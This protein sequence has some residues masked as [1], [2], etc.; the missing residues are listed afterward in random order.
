MTDL[1]FFY[2]TLMSGFRRPGRVAA[3]PGATPVGRGWIRAAL[4]DLGIYPAAIPA[5]D[6][7]GL[8]RSAPDAGFATPSSRRWTRSKASARP[9]PTPASTPA[10]DAGDVR[11]RPRAPTPGSTSTTRRSAGRS[12]SSR[13]TT[14]NTSESD[15]TP[16]AQRSPSGGT[17]RQ[18]PRR[19]SLTR[20]NE[21]AR[22][23]LRARAPAAS[24][25]I[26]ARSYDP[27]QLPESTSMM[28]RVRQPVP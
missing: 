12:G 26:R 27:D 2:G 8:G 13:A 20:F 3:R 16:S 24:D 25:E 21:R 23:L 4:F 17:A 11:G 9:S 14:S 7:R 10:R 22:S 18:S 1:V 15:S 19:P 28:L 5:D 6:S